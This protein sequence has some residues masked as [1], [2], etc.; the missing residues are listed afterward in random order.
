MELRKRDNDEVWKECV[1]AW[2]HRLIYD[3]FLIIFAFAVLRVL[4][5][6]YARAS[7]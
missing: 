7:V 5:Q 4:A 2:R 6:A 3:A 1:I